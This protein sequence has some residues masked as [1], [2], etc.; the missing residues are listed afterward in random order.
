M[1]I[2]TATAETRGAVWVS[3]RGILGYS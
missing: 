1:K 3:W 2:E